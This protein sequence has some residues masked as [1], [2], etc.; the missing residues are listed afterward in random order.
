MA[1]NVSKK[2]LITGGAG[3]IGSRLA[4]KLR[5]MNHSVR[6]LDNL[7]PQVHHDMTV[8]AELEGAGC[9]F[10]LGDVLDRSLLPKVMVGCNLVYHLAAETGT[11][12]SMYEVNRYNS[13]NIDGTVN[14]LEAIKNSGNSI[15]KIV[16]ASSRSV[17]GEGKYFCPMHGEKFPSFRQNADL[18]NGHFEHRCDECK[19]D[20]IPVATDEQSPTSPGSIYAATKRYQ[21]DLVRL[22]HLMNGLSATVFRFQNVY[23]PG[24]S[25]SNPYTGIIS[26]FSNL[27]RAKKTINIFEDGLSIRDFVYVD[28][29]VHF[30]CEELELSSNEYAV[31]NIGSGIKSTVLDVVNHLEVA[32]NLEADFVISKQVRSGDIRSNFADLKSL[33]RRFRSHKF[34]ALN[35]GIREFTEW[36]LK[37]QFDN[38]TSYERSLETLRNNGLLK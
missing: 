3:F 26:I 1:D 7:S 38:A 11:G 33:S 30:L 27:I 2:I 17:Y 36:A 19:A 18:L 23:G 31:I 20:L 35:D 10:I 5:S 16:L 28:D 25:L 34:L 24:Q 29:V 21:E 12:Q 9:E 13:I 15:E 4:K 32:L 37:K 14:I 8:V 22:Y 6:V